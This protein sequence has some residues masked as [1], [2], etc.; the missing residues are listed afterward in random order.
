MLK[1]QPVTL[2]LIVAVLTYSI[3]QLISIRW[4]RT[5]ESEP[6]C[7]GKFH[8]PSRTVEAAEAAPGTGSTT[9][10]ATSDDQFD[11]G[12]YRVVLVQGGDAWSQDHG[13]HD[14]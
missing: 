5:T 7:G 4:I 14:R 12:E 6:R 10:N 9:L 11:L 3:L 13:R 2:G 1:N 8:W